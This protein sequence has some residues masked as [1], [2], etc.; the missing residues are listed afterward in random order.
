MFR[1]EMSESVGMLFVF[2]EEAPRAFWMKNTY[3]ELDMI[4]VSGDQNVVTVLDHV[5][6][7]TETPRPSGKPAKYV[8]ELV[9]G[10]AEK[11]RIAPGSKLK[12][13]TPVEAQE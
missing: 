2:P 1:K 13:P 5:P 7:L 10:A 12:L 11:A 6:P 4:F 9:G 8:I 3:L